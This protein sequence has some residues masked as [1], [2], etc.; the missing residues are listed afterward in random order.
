M[1]LKGEY[2]GARW[3]TAAGLKGVIVVEVEDGQPEAAGPQPS[4]AHAAGAI[5]EHLEGGLTATFAGSQVRWEDVLPTDG[6]GGALGRIAKVFAAQLQPQTI[7][8][9]AAPCAVQLLA[10]AAAE[11]LNGA[12]AGPGEAAL[13]AF[14]DAGDVAE[15]KPRKDVG[16]LA[17]LDE[18]EAV[19]LLHAGGD[20]GQEAV[21]A[22]ADRAPKRLTGVVTNALLD[23]SRELN[24]SGGDALRPGELAGEFVDR[25][26]GMHGHALLNSGDDAMVHLDVELWPRLDE[27]NVRAEAASIAHGDAGPDAEAAGLVAGGDTTGG[28]G[29]NGDNRDGKSAQLGAQLLLNR[30]EV[31]V[32]VEV[33]PRE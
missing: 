18:D 26:G 21:G 30:G 28:F 25:K 32:E 19:R 7:S 27:H 17:P 4:F 24:G 22:D 5:V 13:H 20:L 12:N 23:A 33:K 11:L 9:D 8:E 14:A 2:V 31:G 1:L 3:D 16:E 15:L 29:H 10:A 6:L